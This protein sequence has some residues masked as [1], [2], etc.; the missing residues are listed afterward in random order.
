MAQFIFKHNNIFPC[1]ISFSFPT[2][3]FIQ[4]VIIFAGDNNIYSILNTKLTEQGKGY[5][6][7]YKP[8]PFV[9]LT[10]QKQIVKQLVHKSIATFNI[11]LHQ[12]PK[13]EAE[14]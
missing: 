4:S 2:I 5:L 13:D 8:N 7:E 11:K 9:M 6:G 12:R 10:N 14:Y 3:I 1:N